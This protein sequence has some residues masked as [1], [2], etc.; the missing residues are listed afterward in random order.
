LLRKII[1]SN[2]EAKLQTREITGNSPDPAV[3]A[4]PRRGGYSST[5]T[6]YNNCDPDN[7]DKNLRARRRR[8]H[9]WHWP[10]CV[11]PKP[12]LIRFELGDFA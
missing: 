4:A 3:K 2:R 6:H 1:R 5:C 11:E 10:Q 9:P 8:G 12:E 7:Q